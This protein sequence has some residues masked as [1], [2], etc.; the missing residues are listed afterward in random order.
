MFPDTPCDVLSKDC[1]R[2]TPGCQALYGDGYRQNKTDVREQFGIRC[3]LNHVSR[4]RS[5]MLRIGGGLPPRE[6]APAGTDRPA[7]LRPSKRPAQM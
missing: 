1:N 2:F 7:A 5:S 3:R 4:R 6:A